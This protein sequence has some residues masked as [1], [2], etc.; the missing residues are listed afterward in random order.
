MHY[1]FS[2]KEFAVTRS[3]DPTKTPSEKICSFN[4]LRSRLAHIAS[5]S[6][7]ALFILHMCTYVRHLIGCKVKSFGS[8]Y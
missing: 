5:S 2:L 8:E 1:P 4:K 6:I 3:H 7:N